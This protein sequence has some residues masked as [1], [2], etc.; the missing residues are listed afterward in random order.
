MTFIKMVFGTSL[1]TNK[2]SKN[3]LLP[4]YKEKLVADNRKKHPDTLCRRNGVF[5]VQARP[6]YN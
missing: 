1:R 4:S 6:A 5:D 2:E 3:K